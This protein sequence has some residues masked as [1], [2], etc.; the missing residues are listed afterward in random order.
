M[1]GSQVVCVSIVAIGTELDLIHVADASM[2][3]GLRA[4]RCL[5]PLRAVK[6]M[7][8][9]RLILGA[10]TSSVS[11]GRMQDVFLLTLFF[12]SIYAIMGMQLFGGSLRR[13]CAYQNPFAAKTLVYPDWSEGAFPYNP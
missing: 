13:T 11:E 7:P 3:Q 1:H 9:L 2:L 4:L 12:F 8:S 10:I 5:R 6:F